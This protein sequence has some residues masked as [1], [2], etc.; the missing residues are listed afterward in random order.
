MQG[1]EKTYQGSCH[2]GR[3][4]FEMASDLKS[5]LRC[6]CSICKRKGTPM[7]ATSEGSFKLTAGEE[8]L[9]L[10]QFNT[11]LARHYFCKVCGIYTHH[12][13]RSNPALTRVNAGCLDGIDP[14]T[15]ETQLINGAALSV[16]GEKN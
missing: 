10:Y 11:R 15:L 7:V 3:V 6:N 5:V 13:P 9:S 4:K 8:F 1:T 16:E 14:L 12:N 2:C